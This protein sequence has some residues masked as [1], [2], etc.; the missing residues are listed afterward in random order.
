MSKLKVLI[1]EP[2]KTGRHIFT[3]LITRLGVSVT[4]TTS[5]EE[6]YQ[7]AAKDDYHLICLSQKLPDDEGINVCAKLRKEEQYKT[8]TVLLVT[9]QKSSINYDFAF[10]NGVT[11]LIGR[12]ELHRF[13]HAVELLIERNKPIEG[14][15]LVVEDSRSQAEY[16]SVLLEDMGLK[17]VVVSSAEQA[18]KELAKSDYDLTIIDVVLAGNMTGVELVDYIRTLPEP[19]NSLRVLAMSGYEDSSRRIKLFNLGVDDFISKPIV[20]EELIAR[21]R[22]LLSQHY[23][24]EAAKENARLSQS[25]SQ[26]LD[27]SLDIIGRFDINGFL[28]FMNP[29]MEAKLDVCVHN[30][31]GKHYT[32]L[33]LAENTLAVY[34]QAISDLLKN[35]SVV[36]YQYVGK[37]NADYDVQFSPESIDGQIT[38]FICSARDITQ[39]IELQKELLASK[40][41]VELASEAKTRFLATMSHE[42]RTPL[43]AISGF[44]QLMSHKLLDSPAVDHTVEFKEYLTLIAENAAHL[45]TLIDDVLDL[46][47]IEADKLD[48]HLEMVNA[49]RLI[50]GIK[51]GF[52]CTCLPRDIQLKVELQD[53]KTSAVVIDRV[54]TL[55]ILNNLI[56]N[57]IKFSHV[58]GVVTVYLTQQ[59]DKLKISV[60]DEGIGIPKDG[61]SRIFSPFE[62]VDNSRTRYYGGTGLG[63]S[64][65][66]KLTDFL[67]GSI[68]INSLENKG[69]ECL[70]TLPLGDP[71]KA[72]VAPVAMPTQST[73]EKK[74]HF[75][76][77]KVLVVEDSLVNQQLM[78]ASLHAL[79]LTVKVA[80]NGLIGVEESVNW[81]P[82]IVLM[83]MHMPKMDGLEATTKI[84]QIAGL[85]KLP[86]FGLSA[87]AHKE[88]IQKAINCGVSEYLTKPLD[89]TAL[90]ELLAK[91]LEPACSDEVDDVNE[92]NDGLTDESSNESSEQSNNERVVMS[93]EPILNAEKGITYAANNVDLY[94]K[95][96]GTFISQYEASGR[97]LQTMFDNGESDDAMKLAH[98]MKGVSSTLGM[99]S[100]SDVAKGMQFSFANEELTDM[101]NTIA[102]YEALLQQAITEARAYCEG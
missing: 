27:N 49:Q 42:L 101:G 79:G 56:G 78:T 63:L 33:G 84:R 18:I 89:F 13:S 97:Q 75:N 20:R 26:L 69:T 34:R 65:V 76:G 54:K 5:A 50:E 43:N 11:Q 85:E 40:E 41:A 93:Q 90:S 28:L 8:T 66:R 14:K 10:T 36:R 57:A 9:P 48:L 87:E 4:F 47:Q 16:V 53:I 23:I 72:G 88:Y 58:G 32:E 6:T 37:N 73:V 31:I 96:L 99:D 59:G 52:E 25:L 100:L 67:G 83:D 19:K 7:E 46:S 91:Y 38:S 30:E 17:V 77:Q 64:I 71:T 51:T 80:E 92:G 45:T 55:N 15:V 21:V 44:G 22:G 70:L 12:H 98:T 68:V 81:Q 24:V 86:I 95:L 102:R 60:K 74:A 3:Q 39:L 61:M 82:D 94:K 35:K 29:R 62:Q 2:S 1:A